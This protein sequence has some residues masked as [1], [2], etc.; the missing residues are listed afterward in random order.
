MGIFILVS[1]YLSQLKYSLSHCRPGSVA[2]LQRERLESHKNL[3]MI[4]T[5]TMMMVITLLLLMIIIPTI[6]YLYSLE[7]SRSAVAQSV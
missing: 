5:M 4:M 7:L 3:M 2:F 6:N 1:P